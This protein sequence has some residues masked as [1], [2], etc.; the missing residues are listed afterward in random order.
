MLSEVR[1][2]PGIDGALVHFNLGNLPISHAAVTNSANHL[3]L[4]AQC[5]CKEGDITEKTASLPTA[6]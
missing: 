3:P 2:I 6:E 1:G 5:A 4:V